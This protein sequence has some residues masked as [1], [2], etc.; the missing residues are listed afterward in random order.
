MNTIRSV[1]HVSHYLRRN[2]FYGWGVLIVAGGGAYYFAKREINADRAERAA[3][4]ERRRQA[5]HRIQSSQYTQP[6]PPRKAD[7]HPNPSKEAASDPV[8][9]AEG[10]AGRSE[11]GDEGG[12]LVTRSSHGQPKYESSEPFRSKKGDRFS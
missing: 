4:E 10:H 7:A 9:P 11:G 3:T 8:S 12:S 1:G 6:P 2:A 5:M